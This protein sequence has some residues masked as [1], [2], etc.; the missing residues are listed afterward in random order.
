MD[1]EVITYDCFWTPLLPQSRSGISFPDTHNCKN[2]P[3]NTISYALN[4][5]GDDMWLFLNITITPITCR[6][7]LLAASYKTAMTNRKITV[8][9]WGGQ[10][11]Y[12]RRLLLNPTVTPTTPRSFPLTASRK[13]PK[14]NKNTTIYA[15]NEQGG[16]DNASLPNHVQVFPILTASHNTAKTNRE[17]IVSDCF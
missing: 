1:I 9:V 3:E 4:G 17:V 6:S 2:K 14:T 5:Q 11:G 15:L 8:Y 10:E 12:N 13:T 7:T 16:D